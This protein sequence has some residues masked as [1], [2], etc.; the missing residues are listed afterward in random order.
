MDWEKAFVDLQT[1]EKDGINVVELLKSC[2]DVTLIQEKCLSRIYIDQRMKRCKSWKRNSNRL[3]ART[4][5][6]CVT[7]ITPQDWQKVYVSNHFWGC[8]YS[9]FIW[10]ILRKCWS[11]L[12][13][14]QWKVQRQT[15]GIAAVGMR[16]EIHSSC[17]NQDHRAGQPQDR[18]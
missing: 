17:E 16:D 9:E 4:S 5:N 6:P 3:Q 1:R 15:V 12:Q 18:E 8:S 2:G 14:G 11:M 7:D 10:E 13:F